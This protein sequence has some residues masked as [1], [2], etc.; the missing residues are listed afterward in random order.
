MILARLITSILDGLPVKPA[1]V[2]IVL[3]SECTISAIK[4]QDQV[5]EAWF[6]NKVAEV[7]N[8]LEGWRRQGI[9]VHPMHH[10]SSKDNVADLVIK[11]LEKMKVLDTS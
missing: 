8:H 5:L 11:G 3:D 4:A 7:N 2:F 9:L 1:S 10:W 6:T